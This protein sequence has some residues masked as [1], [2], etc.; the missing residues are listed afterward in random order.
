LRRHYDVASKFERRGGFL[1]L[2]CQL[3]LGT[4][5]TLT[6]MAFAMELMAS[7]AIQNHLAS[8]IINGAVC[9]YP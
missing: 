3:D 2:G 8:P 4:D 7:V 6:G 1:A 5:R 9:L